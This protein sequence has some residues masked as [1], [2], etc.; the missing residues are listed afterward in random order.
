MDSLAFVQTNLDDGARFSERN[1][2]ALMEANPPVFELDK[3]QL[4]KL[5]KL[6]KNDS[7]DSPRAAALLAIYEGLTQSAAAEKSGL[8]LPQLRYWLG[9]F[10]S[11]GLECFTTL[12]SQKESKPKKDKKSKTVKDKKSD[13]KKKSAKKTKKADKK[14]KKK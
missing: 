5:Q 4:K 11:R 2:A 9:R 6:S 12:N 7:V 1:G 14:K 8:T 10:R 13:S 3:K